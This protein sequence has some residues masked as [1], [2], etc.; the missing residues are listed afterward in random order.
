MGR[1]RNHGIVK[2]HY[3]DENIF[4]SLK[5][6]ISDERKF[7]WKEWKVYLS[8]VQSLLSMKTITL[9]FCVLIETENKHKKSQ[10]QTPFKSQIIET[11]WTGNFS[12]F[13][14]KKMNHNTRFFLKH[15]SYLLSFPFVSPITS[16]LIWEL[17]QI[18]Q[19]H[20]TGSLEGKHRYNT[21]FQNNK[22]TPAK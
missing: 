14:I 18:L 11:Q 8:K 17:I 3:K 15:Y 4:L 16:W 12:L 13:F 22:V 20:K 1:K 2:S 19:I 9:P 6:T 10:N 5:N 21:P 7:L